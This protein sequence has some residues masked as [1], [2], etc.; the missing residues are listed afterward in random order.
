MHSCIYEY[1]MYTSVVIIQKLNENLVSPVRVQVILA[2]ACFILN[3]VCVH[4]S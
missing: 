3:S 4:T 1:G 2:N